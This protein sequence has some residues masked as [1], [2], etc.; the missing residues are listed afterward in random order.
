ME[1]HYIASQ[2]DGKLVEGDM[3]A[4]TVSD[5]LGFIASKNWRP[6]SVKP[7]DTRRRL[8]LFRGSVNLSDQ[9]FVSKYLALMLKI[10]TGLLQAINILISDFDKLA[11]KEILMEIRS[12]LEQGKQFFKTFEKYPQIFSPVTV[13]LIKAGEASGNLDHVFED[14]TVSLTKQ[15]DLHDQIKGALI[16]PIILIVGAIVIMTLIITI[17]LPKIAGVFMDSGFEPPAFSRI[18]F[19]LGFFMRDAGAYILG[20][21]V[22]VGSVCFYL[23]RSSIVFRKFAISVLSDLPFVNQVIKKIALQRFARTLSSLVRAGL[24]I[25]EALEITS[26]A[27]GNLELKESL[28]RISREGLAKGLTIGD[29]FKREPFFP[30]TVVNLI[31]IS[32]KAGHI[33]EVLETLSDFYVKEIDGSVKSLVAFLEPILL[34][35]IGAAIAIIALAIIVPIYQLTTQF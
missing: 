18:V 6:V 11:V 12:N 8:R 33:E 25:T 13:N 5:V 3:D 9:I 20:V 14:L 31:S 15:K 21:V 22:A 4:G 19:S 7:R 28:L 1:F 34:L 26:Q 23:F 2:A 17:A 30:Q 35:F 32:E 16:Y 27:T 29:A 10:G 24:P